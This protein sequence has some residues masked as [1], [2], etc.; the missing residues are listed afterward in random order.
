MKELK[1]GLAVSEK[2]VGR[3]GPYER[4][5][6]SKCIVAFSIYRDYDRLLKKQQ[7]QQN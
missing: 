4:V 6:I 5:I 7:Q 2:L 3:L 1:I